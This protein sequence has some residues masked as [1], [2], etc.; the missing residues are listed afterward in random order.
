LLL[1]SIL[2]TSAMVTITTPDLQL[3]YLV[4]E[5]PQRDVQ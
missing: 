1:S 5:A 2:T 4:V 3:G